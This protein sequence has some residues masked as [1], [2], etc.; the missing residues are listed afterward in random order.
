MKKSSKSKSKN[1]G[2]V[3]TPQYIVE[4]M[5]GYI[6]YNNDSFRYQY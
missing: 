4:S 2:Q 6:G 3:F 1:I 5:L